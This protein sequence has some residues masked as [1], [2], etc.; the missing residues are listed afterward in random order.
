MVFLILVTDIKGFS[1]VE[2]FMGFVVL[3]FLVVVGVLRVAEVSFLDPGVVVVRL[4]VLEVGFKMAVE[5]FKA[6]V[7]GSFSVEVGTCVL[8]VG[9]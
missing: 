8:V 3:C 9:F 4:G 6:E 1:V 5:D 7:L 2:T